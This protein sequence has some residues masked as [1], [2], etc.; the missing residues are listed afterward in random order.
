LVLCA[1]FQR[2]VRSE[3]SDGLGS[4][5]PA[6]PARIVPRVV[7][8][9]ARR[10]ATDYLL[11]GAGLAALL[12]TITVFAATTPAGGRWNGD[13]QL[14]HQY[15]GT[16]LDGLLSKTD[17]LSWYPPL[18]LVPITLPR[19]IA[20]GLP[21]YTFLFTLEMSLAAGA[22]VVIV[23][24]VA[25]RA[26]GETSPRTAVAWLVALTLLTA[27]VLPWRYDIIPALAFGGAVLAVVSGAPLA[28]G[29]LIGLG[30]ALKIW[31]AAVLPALFAWYWLRGTK[32]SAG[33]ALLGFGLAAGVGFG[34]YVFF[35]PVTPADL[36]RFQGGR[37]LQL[38]S[39]PAS[40]IGLLAATGTGPSPSVAFED[41]SY[42]LIGPG[43]QA[44][45]QALTFLGPII[46]LAT[47]A[48]TA[49]C[50][51]Q[52]APSQPSVAMLAMGLTA[53]ILALIIG[54]RVIS[55]Q[56][57]IWLLPVIPFL[58]NRF[59]IAGAAGFALTAA[60]FPFLYDGLIRLELVPELLLFLRNLVM[61]ALWAAAIVWLLQ[62]RPAM[63]IRTH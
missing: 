23:G 21:G 60:I 41:F 36:L 15:A 13:I 8:T 31:P 34:L 12:L 43:A 49:W 18:V 17:F 9:L 2:P 4:E 24:S 48:A 32:R 30:T 22:L 38:E 20:S 56:Y 54:N 5:L 37:P 63:A 6:H 10:V 47:F 3:A 44:G 27:A 1:A 29:A 46:L 45:I 28:A 40:V 59:R 51:R 35:A 7:S 52:S 14:Y 53:A 61:V 57:V 58:P 16:F 62:H 33:L 39:L 19:L 42:D 55:P 26:T 25:Q 50:F 11:V